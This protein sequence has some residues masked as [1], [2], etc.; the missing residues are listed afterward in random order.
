VRTSR[1]PAWESRTP[2]ALE[3][4]FPGRF[5]LVPRHLT[6]PVAWADARD[7]AELEAAVIAALASE[8]FT[9][10]RSTGLVT[11]DGRLLMKVTRSGDAEPG[12]CT[13][14]RHSAPGV[15]V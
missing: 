4:R 15:L 14:P 11:R 8:R 13:T 7:D 2:P 12:A 3:S 1:F 9:F 10:D 6:L 5:Q